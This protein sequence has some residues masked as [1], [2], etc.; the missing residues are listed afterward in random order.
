MSFSVSSSYEKL[1]TIVDAT[2]NDALPS[3]AALLKATNSLPASL[4]AKGLGEAATEAH[5]LSDIIPGFNGPK[6]SSNYYGFV[7]GG[8]LPIAEVADNIVTAF[9]QN[10]QVHLPDQSVSTVVEDRASSMLV[11][12]LNLGSG[13][14]GRTF[15]A[16]ATG[17][18]ILGLACGR[19]A[20]ITT[21]LKAAGI[22][23][24]VG[25]LGLLAACLKAGVKEVQ[26]LT[27][28]GHSSL[29][30]AAS[31]VGLGR[32]S[33][34]DIPVSADEPWRLDLRTLEHE[35]RRSKE[36]VLSIV[37]ISAGEVNTG[38]FATNGLDDMRRIRELCDE[39]G[40]WVHVDAAFGLFARSL[41]ETD[42]F[43]ILRSKLSGI[44]LADSITSDCHK[45]LNV[46]YDC[47]I[48][49]TRSADTLSSIFQNPNA[50]YLASGPASIHSPLN[51]GLENSRRFRA[52]PVYAVL[53]AYGKYELAEIFA[54]QVR[55]ARA[56]SKFL[57]DSEEYELLPTVPKSATHKENISVPNIEFG[58]THIIVLFRAKDEDVNTELVKR[59]NATR[60]MYVS[61]TRWEGRPACRIAISTWRIDVNRDTNLI[62]EV[63]KSILENRG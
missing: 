57:R 48:F 45:M 42:E 5:L 47:G 58:D 30:K 34:K 50:A 3:P 33:V 51:V 40:A 20:V 43:E 60:K 17:A 46:P 61:G 4:P 25:E 59:I 41:P 62:K 29:Y 24:G 10:V 52:L 27:T 18:N 15:T 55:L 32:A 6:T 13:W 26:V 39:F 63:L 28:M 8:V 16:G 38:M 21:R 1:R 19:E 7:T 22:E 56:V 37:A 53:L 49:F 11:E 2:S 12:L 9:D 44:E 35:L 14:N 54:R 36:G 23:E 31:V